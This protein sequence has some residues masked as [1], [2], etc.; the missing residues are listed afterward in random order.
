MKNK[1]LNEGSENLT[2]IIAKE[3]K[4]MIKKMENNKAPDE[5]QITIEVTSSG[6][7]G[8]PDRIAYFFNF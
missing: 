6:R 5:D 1:L 7:K 8:L 3:E 2:D 4:N